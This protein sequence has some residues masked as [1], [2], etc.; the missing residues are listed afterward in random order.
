[1][2]NCLPT[3]D[4]LRIKQ[5]QINNVCPTCNNAPES[6]LHTLVQ[7]TFVESRWNKAGIA[8]IAGEF[9]SFS[10]WLQLVFIARNSGAILTTVMTCWV[11][12]TN[13][14]ELVWNQKCLDSSE[15]LAKALSV[16]N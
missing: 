11:L 8:E 3:K 6:A 4:L 2:S 13:R 12:W 5:I 10:D 7:C 9:N 16:L 1:M 15:V 14:N